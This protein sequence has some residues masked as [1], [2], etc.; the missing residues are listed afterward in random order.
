[1]CSLDGSKVWDVWLEGGIE[2]IRNYCETDVL[3]TWL[4][5]LAFEK[6]RGHFS[7]RDYESELKLVRDTLESQ[8][9]PHLNQFL[10]AWPA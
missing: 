6:M 4:V 5:Y 8:D 3:N 10:D 7:E 1:M 2:D 9:R